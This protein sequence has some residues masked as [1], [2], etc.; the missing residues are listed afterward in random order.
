LRLAAVAAW[1]AVSTTVAAPPVLAAP[2]GLTVRVEPAAPRQG[3]LTV[4]VVTGASGALEVTGSLGPGPLAFFPYGGGHAAV[5]GIDLEAKAGPTPWRVDVVDASGAT[6][7]VTGR[8]VVGSRQFPVQRLTLPKGQVD[9]DP[10]TERRALAETA[11]L[12]ALYATLTP[13]RL[14][15]GRFVR[16]LGGES[17]GEGF[18]SRRIINGQPR[19]PH[20]GLDYAAERGTPV[21]AANRGRVALVGDFFFPGRFV[22]LDHG[23]GLYTLY[24]HLDRVDVPEGALVERGT[25]L[26]AVGSTGRATGPHLHFAAQAGPARVDPDTLLGTRFSD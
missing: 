11:R 8:L 4:V 3:D 1:L 16:P 24:M 13:E 14:W 9:L 17:K 21:V 23:L 2:A 12:R 19:M 26:G 6:R 15:R 7:T 10:E 20:S 18:G 22:A 5:A 25:T